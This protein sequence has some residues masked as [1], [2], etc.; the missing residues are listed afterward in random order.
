M[1]NQQQFWTLK[2]KDYRRWSLCVKKKRALMSKVG[3]AGT[4]FEGV[5]QK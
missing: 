1:F 5:S 3:D 2:K 4:I